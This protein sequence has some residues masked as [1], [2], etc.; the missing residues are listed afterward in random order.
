MRSRNIRLLVFCLGCIAV[1]T[2]I[3]SSP[4]ALSQSVDPASVTP[5]AG[6][7]PKIWKKTTFTNIGMGELEDQ[8]GVGFGFTQFKASDGVGLI[9][10]DKDF[11][12]STKA[13]EYFK[14]RLEEAAKVIEQGN[15]LNDV[16]EV[17]GVR[18]QIL[19][20]IDSSKTSP[21]LLWTDGVR[22]QEIYSSSLKDILKLE[23]VY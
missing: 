4:S 23:K 13:E 15:K 1:H 10:L 5:S 20:R 22:L 14:K 6:Q 3:S 17:V 21:A 7:N 11:A 18:A 2:A 16:G 19:L 8:D 12:D 9:V